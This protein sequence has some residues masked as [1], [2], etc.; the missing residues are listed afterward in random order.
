MIKIQKD[1]YLNAYGWLKFK[2]I[3]LRF[4]LYKFIDY[5]LLTLAFI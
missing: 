5:L 4:I 1:L 2:N 3:D